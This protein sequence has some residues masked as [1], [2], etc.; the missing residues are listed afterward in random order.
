MSAEAEPEQANEELVKQDSNMWEF[1]GPPEGEDAESPATNGQAEIKQE[2]KD[3]DATMGDAA[4]TSAGSK[5]APIPTPAKAGEVAKS[6]APAQP[7]P[8]K[9]LAPKFG[10]GVNQGKAFEGRRQ[11]RYFVLKSKS[12]FNVDQSV[13][14]GIWATQVCRCIPSMATRQL[15]HH[16]AMSCRQYS[17]CFFS[18]YPA[19]AGPHLRHDTELHSSGN[20]KDSCFVTPTDNETSLL[21]V[22]G[23]ELQ[24]PQR[25]VE[26]HSQRLMGQHSCIPTAQCWTND[27]PVTAN[28]WLECPLG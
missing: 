26:Q 13:E 24:I 25:C 16:M 18:P 2:D 17:V 20:A 6:G 9:Q 15:S 10:S 21:T 28:E 12:M 23:K 27:L 7:Q 4:L 11:H 14:K 5:H 8:A 22:L 3:G 1:E 19:Y